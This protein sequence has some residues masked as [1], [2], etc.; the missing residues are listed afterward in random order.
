M[1]GSVGF[2]EDMMSL[3]SDTADRETGHKE[4][5]P[6]VNRERPGYPLAQADGRHVSGSLLILLIMKF[7]QTEYRKEC[8]K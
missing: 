7:C 3:P 5:Y 2:A 6:P 8:E 4:P 1:T